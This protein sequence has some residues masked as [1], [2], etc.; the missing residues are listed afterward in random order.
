MPLDME[1]EKSRN[2]LIIHSSHAVINNGYTTTRNL[3]TSFP[4]L[5]LFHTFGIIILFGAIYSGGTTSMLSAGLPVTGKNMIAG[6]KSTKS[7]IFY[8][9]PYT[10]KL[11]AEID[12]D[13]EAM[14]MDRSV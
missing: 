12:G 1:V 6:L 9:V 11:V 3:N 10:L 4:A 13:I 7:D 14:K 2:V 5:P 8:L